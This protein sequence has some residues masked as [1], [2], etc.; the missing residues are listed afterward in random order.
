[1]E[2]SVKQK[3]QLNRKNQLNGKINFK[4]KSVKWKYWLNGKSG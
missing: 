2:K 1:M 3:N 4:K